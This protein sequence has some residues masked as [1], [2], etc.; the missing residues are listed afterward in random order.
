[1]TN[2]NG[3]K[4]VKKIQLRFI[5]SFRFM[6]SSLD[7]LAKNLD[8]DQCKNL[9]DFY[10][11]SGA[12]GD[13]EE[14]HFKLMRR[15][16]VY[17]YEYMDSWEKFEETELPPKE[18]FYSKL[19][20]KGISDK[21]YE[22]AQKVWRSM[23][24]EGPKRTLGDYHDLYLMTDVLLLADVFETFRETCL[25]HYKLD[26]A[27]FYT[28][29]G[30]AW[31]AALKH[32]AEYCEHED[33]A[34]NFKKRR[35]CD[36]CPNEF[37]LELLM[38]ID[39]LLMF[40]QGIRGGI[41]QAVKRY[42]KAN[43]KYMSDYDSEQLSIFLQYLDANNLYGWGMIQK[44]PT[45]GFKW[46]KKVEEF[47]PEKIAKLVK[48]D[49][50]GYIL[51]VDVDYPKELHKSHNELPF[52]A[53][54]MK[55]RKVEKLVP[56][57]NN[58][59]KYVCHIRTLDQALKHGLVLKKVHRVIKFEQSAWLK[60]YI[61]KNTKLR[62]AAKNEF[63]KDFFKLMNNSVF[64]KTMENIRNH[65]DM[66]LATNE[67]K[68][69]KYVMKP[70][71]KDSVRFS[72][73]LMGVELG[74]IEIIMNKPVYLGQAILD[75]S[76]IVMYEF[77]YDYMK[78]K[79]GSKVKL[80]Y[81]DTDSFVYEIETEDFYRDIAEDVEARFDTS[82]YS[83]DDKRPLPIGKN[84]KIIG[85][86]KDESNGKIMT[87]FVALRAKMY[88]YRLLDDK[89]PE[90][91]KCKGTKK[92][93]VAETLTF[94][95]YKRCLFEG[96]TVYREQMLFEHKKHEVYTVNKCKI[97]LN[98]DDDKRIIQEDGITTLARGFV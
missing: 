28:A 68:Y 64:G 95:D 69:K 12:A 41:T 27:H 93:V 49:K 38:D 83:E 13:Q 56:N 31:K 21:D 9:R 48:K 42:V 85:L 2:K 60:P 58:K 75:L 57:L 98:R 86:M 39:M 94:E 46:V 24:R 74:K 15:K 35:D 37:R 40:E 26:P 5:D 84:K 8:D 88:A 81:M 62:K 16:G 30:L 7:K 19:N 50:K 82:G 91:K 22:H 87:E 3:K 25:K 70:N 61:M 79:Y 18:A 23:Y 77:H 20:M 4:V 89:K 54:R 92:C 52:L 78:P 6:A 97:A 45:H 32:A 73:H 59:K 55:I 66:K 63:E 11:P 51:E 80:C 34:G 71:F 67:E 33:D 65:R 47:T 29:P 14:E 53:E 76:K 90:D 96:K 43:N 10:A 17:P 72:E 36:K 1:M 44:L